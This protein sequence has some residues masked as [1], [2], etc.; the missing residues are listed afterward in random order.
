M[1]KSAKRYRVAFESLMDFTDF[2]DSSEIKS[3]EDLKE[4]F[5]QVEADNKSK[6][7]RGLTKQRFF[8]NKDLFDGVAREV[9]I[10]IQT[11]KPVVNPTQQA[12]RSQNTFRSVKMARDHHL[13]VNY[14]GKKIFKSS[15]SKNKTVIT[16]WRDSKGRFTKKPKLE[17]N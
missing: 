1:V 5:R 6:R 17:D 9:I 7:D 4:F 14:K 13:L 2:K 15:F 3:R 11:G 10:G 8:T 12:I 16:K